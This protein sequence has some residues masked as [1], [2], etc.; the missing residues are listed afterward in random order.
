MTVLVTAELFPVSRDQQEGIVRPCTDD[1]DRD[2]RLALA[3]DGQVGVLRQEVD[4]PE[5]AT[6]RDDDREDRQDPQG[7]AAVGDQQEHD[8]R[9]QRPEQELAVEA[10]ERLG[11]VDRLP[12][13]AGNVDV[14][15]VQLGDVLDLVGDAG[16]Q[17]P[18]LGAQVERHRGLD[19]L[20]V[21]RGDRADHLALDVVHRLQVGG[22]LLH[23]GEVG[24]G[25]PVLVL[26]D[27]GGGDR[28]GVL[29]RLHLLQGLGGLC[30]AGQPR[31]GLVVLHL[32]Q[33]ARR[34]CP[35][36]RRR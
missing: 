18:A 6:E 3:V 23:R 8:H 2:D 35:G 21:L 11:R 15:A 7:R 34:T 28:V 4:Q 20:A 12:T 1:Q 10:L 5:R 24:R 26:V 29:E 19:G 9:E 14:G 17:V 30:V 36:R 16:H 13:G 32:G 31:G 22:L 33:L 27:H 25:E